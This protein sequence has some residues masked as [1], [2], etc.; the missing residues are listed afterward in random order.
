MKVYCIRSLE[1]NKAYISLLFLKEDPW[2]NIST[3]ED[4]VVYYTENELI[5]AEKY[6]KLKKIGYSVELIIRTKKDVGMAIRDK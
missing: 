1:E 2:M 3:I 4:K 5:E 6:L